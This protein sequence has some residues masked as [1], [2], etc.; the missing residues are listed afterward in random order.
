MQDLSD[1]QGILHMLLGIIDSSSLCV[2]YLLKYLHSQA[3]L[4]L[5]L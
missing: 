4:E 2:L 5:E 1:K 3:K